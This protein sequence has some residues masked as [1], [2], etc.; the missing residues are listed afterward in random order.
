LKHQGT[1]E[2]KRPVVE[3]DIVLNKKEIKGVQFGLA[4]RKGSIKDLEPV[5]L[6]RDVINKAHLIINTSKTHLLKV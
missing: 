6:S 4:N 1:I 2:D 3:F 5:L